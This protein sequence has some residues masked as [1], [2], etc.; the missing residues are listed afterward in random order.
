M[1]G[2]HR[3]KKSDALNGIIALK[4]WY[5]NKDI[6]CIRHLPGGSILQY[7]I[8]ENTPCPGTS[9]IWD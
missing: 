8:A 2:Y 6:F 3:E 4:F 7:Y 9:E 5:G 1:T